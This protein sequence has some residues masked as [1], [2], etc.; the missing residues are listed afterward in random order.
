M[1]VEARA[2]PDPAAA[3]IPVPPSDE[4]RVASTRVAGAEAAVSAL[5]AALGPLRDGFLLVFASPRYD[6]PDVARAFRRRFPDVVFAGGTTAGEIGPEGLDEGS[7]VVVHLPG[8]GFVVEAALLPDL[9]SFTVERA[10]DIVLPIQARLS[11]RFR[12]AASR[13]AAA[14]PSP[15]SGDGPSEGG[16]FAMTFLDGMCR[17]EEVVVAGLQRCLDNMP[18]VGGSCG[19]GLDFDGTWVFHDGAAHTNSG[20]LVLVATERPFELVRSEHFEPTDVKLVVTE[21]DGDQR[22]VSEIN[23]EPAALAYAE[24]V[25]LAGD[26]L[27]PLSFASHPVLVRVGG[28]YYSRSIQKMNPDGSLSFFCAIDTGVVLTAARPVDL[29]GALERA[30]GEADA[31]V[32]GAEVVIGFDCVLR[33]LDA[34]NRQV[35]R[36]VEEVHRRHRVVGFNTYGEQYRS[37]HLNQTFTGI[38]I[39]RSGPTAAATA[40]AGEEAP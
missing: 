26:E 40:G 31:A 23:A 1:T 7:L 24:A 10:A 6:A 17:R 4:V 20:V 9:K 37:M 11:R 18:L 39:G 3:P 29:V 13:R 30:L 16:M 36:Q 33:R 14:A 22:R 8:D 2:R 32:G 38:A 35:I 12:E 19:D 21:C 34:Q 25:G 27:G 5:A 15:S 28:E